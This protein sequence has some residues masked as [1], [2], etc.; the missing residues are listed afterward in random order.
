MVI[1]GCQ[2]INTV[3]EVLPLFSFVCIIAKVT[4]SVFSVP[5]EKAL[6][7]FLQVRENASLH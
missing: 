1:V 2:A 5:L 4:K 3:R 6:E 7:K